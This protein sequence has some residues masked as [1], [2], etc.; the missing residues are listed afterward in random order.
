MDATAVPTRP[1][2][3]VTVSRS[4]PLRGVLARPS[5]LHPPGSQDWTMVAAIPSPH[6]VR[7]RQAS[8]WMA[9]G[10]HR[11][12]VFRPTAAEGRALCILR[13]RATPGSGRRLCCGSRLALVVPCGALT[14]LSRSGW[15]R[16]RR[17]VVHR[18][19]MFR[20][21]GVAQG[22]GEQVGRVRIGG[23][24]TNGPVSENGT[25]RFPIKTGLRTTLLGPSS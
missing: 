20:K 2:R 7:L 6:A 22:L 19:P 13:T 3:G 10:A 5:L 16:P 24:E 18:G 11:V 25:M 23:Y 17:Q 12:A 21:F 8:T 14:A 1:E 4:G 9:G 15:P